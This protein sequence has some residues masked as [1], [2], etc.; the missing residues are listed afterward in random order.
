[1]RRIINNVGYGVCA[2][3]DKH[4]HFHLWLLRETSLAVTS[5]SGHSASTDI[6]LYFVLVADALR[7]APGENR[8][9]FRRNKPAAACVGELIHTLGLL[10]YASTRLVTRLALV[11]AVRCLRA[12]PLLWSLLSGVFSMAT[13]L[14]RWPPWRRLREYGH[15]TTA[16]SERPPNRSIR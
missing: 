4:A 3:R 15:A 5:S 8:P 6:Q 7:L 10:V 1:M 14:R 12:A 2:H 11:T 16:P 13:L 9:G